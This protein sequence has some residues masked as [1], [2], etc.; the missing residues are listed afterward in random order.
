M[1]TNVV[2]IVAANSQISSILSFSGHADLIG[3]CIYYPLSGS[4]NTDHEDT[5]KEKAFGY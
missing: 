2:V 3:F 1:L 4:K 5:Y